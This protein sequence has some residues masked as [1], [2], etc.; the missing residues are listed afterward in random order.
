M[1]L[2]SV[3]IVA[4]TGILCA[5]LVV[6]QDDPASQTENP[7]DH[8]SMSKEAGYYTFDETLGRVQVFVDG[9]LAGLGET[10]DYVPFA[11][12]VAVHGKGPELEVSYLDFQFHDSTG[13]VYEPAS[14]DD[15]RKTGMIQH[16]YD[17]YRKNPVNTGETLDTYQFVESDFYPDLAGNYDP[18]HLDRE[19]YLWDVVYFPKPKSLKGELMLSFFT[20]GME[21]GAINIRFK[22]PPAGHG[23]HGKHDGGK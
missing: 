4:I 17:W 15:V 8:L 16:V 2:R 9:R 13:A 21:K 19:T 3:P 20:K 7:L 10:G 1:R 23:K 18:A 5:G 11:V 6:A 22:L 12:V 14:P